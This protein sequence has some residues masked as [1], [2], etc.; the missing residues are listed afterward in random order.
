MTFG[1][2]SWGWLP[3]PVVYTSYDYGAAINEARQLRP[4]A[5]TMKEIGLFLQSVAPAITKVD[6]GPATTASSPKVKIYDDVNPDTGTH[7]Y[8][9]MHNPSSATTDDTFTFPISTSDGTYTVPQ[10]GTLAIDGQDAKTLVA[11]YD[12]D[13]Q[14][15]VY[16]TSEIMTHFVQGSRDVALLYGRD[17]EDGETVLR[18]A[19]QP[20]VKVVSGTVASTYDAATGDLRLN[21]VH[22][23][24]AEVRISHGGRRPLTLL[25]ADNTTADAF[26]RQ[27]TDAGPVLEQGPELVRTASIDGPVLRLTGD[28]SGATTVKVWAPPQRPPRHVERQAGRA[29]DGPRAKRGG[30]GIHRAPARAGPDQP[31]RSVDEPVEVRA[32][33]AGGAAVV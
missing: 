5:S 2:T 19:S 29:V 6:P 9:A 20:T 3:A 16:S 13:G 31:A 24:L 28:T 17:G 27:D 12:M 21:Y 4:K 22:N 10:Q 14:H 7:F 32:R 15:L 26:W 25:L 1:G 23:G 11:D 18:Y 30:R 33:V 8:F